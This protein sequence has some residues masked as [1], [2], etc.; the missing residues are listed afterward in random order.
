MEL[1]SES[2]GEIVWIKYEV[3][4]HGRSFH[5]HELDLSTYAFTL[6]KKNS[7]AKFNVLLHAISFP[8]KKK[9]KKSVFNRQLDNTLNNKL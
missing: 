8:K 1:S 2:P 7:F 5:T 9:K 3:W 4:G 6:E